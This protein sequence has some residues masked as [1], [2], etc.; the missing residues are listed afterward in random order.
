MKVFVLIIVVFLFSLAFVMAQN[1]TD[2]VS[3]SQSNS[4]EQ[5][6]APTSG[7]GKTLDVNPGMTPDNPL[8]FVK[9]IYERVS[10]GNNPETALAYREEKIAEA[11]V[12]INEGK[13]AEAN[14]V[15]DR[16]IQYGN[17]VEKESSPENKDKVQES[18]EIVQNTLED[19]KQ[20]ASENGLEA[21]NDNLDKNMENEKQISTIIYSPYYFIRR[22]KYYLFSI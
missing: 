13:E 11:Q 20:Q 1:E 22:R 3:D 5:T 12:M 19:M 17:I 4:Q 14:K 18:S 10:V 15:L 8:Y 21:V 6:Q 9:D 7:Q 2:V 16:A